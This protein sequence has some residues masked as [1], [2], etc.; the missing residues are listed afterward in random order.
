MQTRL[1]T[2]DLSELEAAQGGVSLSGAARFAGK[3]AK[4]VGKRALLPLTIGSAAYEGYN[5]Y[6]KA[7][8]QGNS[9]GGALWEGAKGAVRDVTGYD[10]WGKYVFGE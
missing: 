5:A 2:L 10:L 1:E 6:D 3:A 8:D 7:R 4:L 9:V